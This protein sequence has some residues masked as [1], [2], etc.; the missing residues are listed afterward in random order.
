MHASSL[1]PN[2]DE[3]LS[4]LPPHATLASR[5]RYEAAQALID[6]A[7]SSFGQEAILSGSAARGVSDEDSDI[8]IV[9]YVEAFPS[10]SE[11]EGWLRP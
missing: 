1:Q 11:R 6:A 4:K 3:G 9:F 10:R 8:E 5:V 2:P 7:P